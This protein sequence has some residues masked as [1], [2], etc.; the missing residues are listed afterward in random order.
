MIGATGGLIAASGLTRYLEGMLFGVTPLHPA[1]FAGAS[2]L[3]ITVALAAAYMPASR[4]TRVD[5]M[6]ALRAE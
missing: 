4:A 2:M 3:F 5:P 1:T 6:V